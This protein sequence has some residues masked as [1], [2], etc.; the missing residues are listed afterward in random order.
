MVARKPRNAE[1]NPTPGEDVENRLRI[2]RDA[3]R[4]LWKGL[5]RTD[6]QTMK[7]EP[8][9]LESVTRNLRD[10]IDNLEVLQVKRGESRVRIDAIIGALS[11]ALLALYKAADT[12]AAPDAQHQLR[13]FDYIVESRNHLHLAITL[14]PAEFEASSTVSP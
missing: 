5:I 2:Y 12:A 1:D 13:F 9:F 8:Y 7:K 11:N 6:W 4:I 3:L 10:V 14:F